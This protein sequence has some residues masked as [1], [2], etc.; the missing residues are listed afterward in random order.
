MQYYSQSQQDKF[1]NDIIFAN[2]EN[3]VF[4]DIGAHD[5]I[6]YSN[7]FFFEKYLN[8]S[9]VCVEPNPPVYKKLVA[10]RKAACYNVCIG[11]SNEVVKFMSIS[12]YSEMLSGM[13]SDYD[14][15]HI[16][17]IES[18][19]K[20][21]GG[22][23]EIIDIEMIDV[24]TILDKEKIQQID[25]CSIDTEGSELKIIK[26]FD[27]SKL[28]IKVIGIENNYN[29][30]EIKDILTNN[31]Y[32]FLVR[33]GVDDFY[34]KDTLYTH[35]LKLKSILFKLRYLVIKTIDMIKYYFNK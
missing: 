19:I 17:R 12:G 18:E 13:L 25:Y 11:N 34:I 21:K 23:S 31:N 30:Q 16:H 3:G 22:S 8:W 2:K 33:I 15:K 29:I 4:L 35:R 14:A 20:E 6:S 28:D 9:G 26:G 1:V 32:K 24:N 5:G 7:S 10:N 27:F